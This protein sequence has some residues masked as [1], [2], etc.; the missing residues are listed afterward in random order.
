MNTSDCIVLGAGG[1]GSAALYHLARRGVNAIGIDRFAPGHDRGSSHGETRIIRQ[2]YFEHPD[3]VPL[4]LRS[5]E[6]WAEL[7]ARRGEK[8]YHETGILEAGPPDGAVVPGVVRSARRHRLDVE[9]LSAR[10]ALGRFPGFRVPEDMT[11][12]FERRAGY[13]RVEACVR[14]HAEEAVKLGAKIM[15]DES[16]LEWKTDGSGVEV[17]TDRA[18][19]RAAR[20][21]IA[22]GP[23]APVILR[24][25]GLRLEVR[26]KP[27]FWHRTADAAYREDRG[28]PCF[29]FE[30]PT[31][32]F[33]GFPEIDG[34]GLKAAEHSGGEPVTD[35]LSVDRSLRPEDKAR[36]DAFLARHLPGVTRDCLKHSACMYTMT[37]D[38]HFVVDRHPAHPQVAFAA[39]L[40]G[41]GFKFTCVLGEALAELVIDGST[42]LPIAFL[43]AGRAGLRKT[44]SRSS[45]TGP[46]APRRRRPK[47]G[48]R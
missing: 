18:T 27:A 11:A 37:P 10:E 4:L 24:D 28:C 46:G 48:R 30:T 2:A 45:A 7:E 16:A 34:S 13:L 5:Y 29:L 6:L 35:P 41:H 14:A 25:L 19:Y 20:M 23:W 42:A 36:V 31:G 15:T 26:R 32:T 47:P 3:Y 44:G 8:L 22:A 43:G 17:R 33:Y 40:S 1:V 39:G 21:I 9:E 12:V 38:E